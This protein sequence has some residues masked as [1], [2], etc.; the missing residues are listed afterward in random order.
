MTCHL[1]LFALLGNPELWELVLVDLRSEAEVAGGQRN[2]RA[3][4]LF[5]DKLLLAIELDVCYM[6]FVDAFADVALREDV[7]SWA[8][9]VAFRRDP[10]FWDVEVLLRLVVA[11]NLDVIRLAVEA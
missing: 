10:V 5:F 7:P 9:H 3:H 4:F 1:Q 6:A 11:A 2:P 8:S